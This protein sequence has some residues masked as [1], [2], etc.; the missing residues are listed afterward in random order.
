MS[1]RRCSVVV[2]AFVAVALAL[3]IGASAHAQV[4]S[5]TR[6]HI[7][8]A[9]GFTMVINNATSQW[10]AVLRRATH[11]HFRGHA[12]PSEVDCRAGVSG[13]LKGRSVTMLW[14]VRPSCTSEVIS[15]VGTYSPR[16]LYGTVSDS[17]L[18]SGTFKASRDG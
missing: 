12:E 8:G 11:G 6:V 14:R 13:T 4:A 16:H 5:R 17:R 1:T 10:D 7:A 15:L 3:S 2:I 9:W 18:G